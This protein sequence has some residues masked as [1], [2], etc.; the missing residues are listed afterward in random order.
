[1]AGVHDPFRPRLDPHRSIYDAFQNE[2]A[3]RKGRSF[4]EWSKAEMDAVLHAAKKVA[5]DQ[6]FRLATPTI[7]MVAAAEVYARG[8][9]DYGLKWTC[10]L[11]RRMQALP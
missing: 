2:A 10:E 8:S 6:S 4:E 7:E 3:M 11:I 9:A 1:M 5:A